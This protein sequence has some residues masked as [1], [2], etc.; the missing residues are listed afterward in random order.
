VP[1][2]PAPTATVG[3]VDA[4]PSAAPPQEKKKR[5]FW[6]KLFGI[7]KDDKARKDQNDKD[8]TK[9]KPVE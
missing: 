4:P 3:S 1:E 7:G 5:G 9:K 8:E 6:S 2:P